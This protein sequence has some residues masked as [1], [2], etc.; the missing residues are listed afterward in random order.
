MEVGPRSKGEPNIVRLPIHL[1]WSGPVEYDLR[2]P[3]QKK[4]VYEIV[5][6]EGGTEDVRRFIE[7]SD[8]ADLLS[9]L[10]LPARVRAAWADYLQL[11]ESLSPADPSG[12]STEV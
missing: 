11:R 4:R 9:D 6:R 8:L 3:I 2:D 7:P 10:V 5:L 1:K 12:A